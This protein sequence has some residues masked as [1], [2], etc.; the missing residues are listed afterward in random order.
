MKLTKIIRCSRLSSSRYK[1]L[2][3]AVTLSQP[4]HRTRNIFAFFFIKYLVLLF[5]LVVEKFQK[6]KV[7][8]ST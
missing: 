4:F 7:F 2:N 5:I 6:L 1:F 3:Y 8:M